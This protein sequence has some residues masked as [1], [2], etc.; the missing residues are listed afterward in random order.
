MKDIKTEKENLR[1]KTL[2]KKRS[3]LVGSEVIKNF[4]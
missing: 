3:A 2:E 1:K 4:L